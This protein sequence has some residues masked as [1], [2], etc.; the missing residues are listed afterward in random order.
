LIEREEQ[1]REPQKIDYLFAN[2]IHNMVGM[3]HGKKAGE[4]KDY[5]LRFEKT[6]NTSQEERMQRAKAMLM[7]FRVQH[8]KE[9]KKLK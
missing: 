6:G 2:L 7:S 4:L 9:A 5:L 3:L 1:E 8:N